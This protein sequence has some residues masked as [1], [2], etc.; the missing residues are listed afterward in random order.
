VF[1]LAYG[2]ILKYYLDEIRLQGVNRNPLGIFGDGICCQANG[3]HYVLMPSLP[4][5]QKSKG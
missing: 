2:Q 4:G 5:P 3:S 1:S